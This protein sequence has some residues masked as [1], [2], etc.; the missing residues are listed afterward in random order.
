MA[1]AAMN[2]L[3]VFSGEAFLS[4]ER[5]CSPTEVP[6]LALAALERIRLVVSLDILLPEEARNG[7]CFSG[8]M[9]CFDLGLWSRGAREQQDECEKLFKGLSSSLGA[10]SAENA[11]ILNCFRRS[12]IY[13]V[14]YS[15]EQRRIQSVESKL[16]TF[17]QIVGRWAYSGQMLLQFQAV[18]CQVFGISQKHKSQ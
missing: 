16:K 15:K 11:Q 5:V 2:D 3:Q 1:L 17:N 4:F 7:K 18:V 6:A 13:A 12:K 8:M 9:R 14:G 10:I